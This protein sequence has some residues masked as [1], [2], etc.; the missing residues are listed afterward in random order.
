MDYKQAFFSVV[1]PTKNRP[2]Y[3][4]DAIRS[5]LSQDFDDF[6]LIVSDN[7]NSSETFEVIEKYTENPR[8]KYF[9]TSEELHMLDHWEFA[10]LKATGKY[11]IV[12]TDRKLLYKDAL[13][14]LKKEIQKYPDINIFSV[15]VKTYDECAQKMGWS[16][17]SIQTRSFN[18]KEAMDSFLNR[19]LFEAEGN[20]D[21]YFPKSQNGVYSNSYASKIREKHGFYFNLPHVSTPDYSSFF[22]N[23]ALS[24]KFVHLNIPVILTQGENVSNGR[25]FGRGNIEKY[26]GS[27]E[28]ERLYSKVQLKLPYIY[29]LITNDFL[30]IKDQVKGNL[31]TLQINKSNYYRC[32]YWEYFQQ[33]DPA[34]VSKSSEQYTIWEKSLLNE[35][36]ST[37]EDVYLYVKNLNSITGEKPRFK[38]R[39]I[40]THITDF[41]NHRFS[42]YTFCNKL[43]KHR[44]TSAL[45]AAGF[46]NM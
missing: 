2:R 3:L 44:F 24:N 35:E 25:Q 36:K 39:N 28:K 22:V 14:K 43:L 17:P 42:K 26:L 6:E 34:Y 20:L 38:F 18:F 21:Y 30:E 46:T 33:C 8:L 7:F 9:R 40:G 37:Q 12:L 45:D 32:L 1:I 11:V 23:M 4:D 29:N 13:K 19:H 10:T 31:E 41:L 27:L 15:R 5:V 16:A